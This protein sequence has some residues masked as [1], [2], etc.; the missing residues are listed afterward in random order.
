MLLIGALVALVVTSPGWDVVKETFFSWSIFKSSFP[1]VLD[2]FWLDVKIF[3]I[4]E[5]VVLILGLLIA[6]I[7]TN[8]APALFP[9]RLLAIV[10]TDVFRGIPTII[11]VYLVGFGVP[12]LE[13]SG[14]PSDVIVLG[15]I[16]LA[17]SYSA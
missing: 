14:L 12:A 13:L 4:V 10:Y 2:A 9:L 6:L 5:V 8:R 1:K 17:L 15:G 11:L 16:A 7:R 3:M